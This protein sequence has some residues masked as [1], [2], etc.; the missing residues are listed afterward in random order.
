MRKIYFSASIF[1]TGLFSG[2]VSNAQTKVCFDRPTI[3][4]LQKFPEQSSKQLLTNFGWTSGGYNE[5]PVSSYFNVSLDY[6]VSSWY[7][8]YTSGKN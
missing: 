2:Y 3:N 6:S 1:F 4:S 7:S 8:S 5:N